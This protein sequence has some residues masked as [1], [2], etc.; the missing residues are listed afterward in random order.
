MQALKD[1]G[2]PTTLAELEARRPI[3]DDEYN[4]ALLIE[5]VSDEL[6]KVSED[7]ESLNKVPIIGPVESPA[8]G[9]P[10]SR[11]QVDATRWFVEAQSELIADLDNVGDMPTGRSRTDFSDADLTTLLPNLS[12]VR[13]AAKIEVLAALH[14]A[15]NHNLTEAVEHCSHA[16]NFSGAVE[17]EPVLISG[18]VAIAVNA[19]AVDTLER[20]LVLGSLPLSRLE[21]LQDQ[22]SSKRR[23]KLAFLGLCGEMLGQQNNY[24][25]MISGKLNPA[26]VVSEGATLPPASIPVLRPLLQPLLFMDQT[27]SLL[28]MRA[29]VESADDPAKLIEAAEDL[30]VQL[31]TLPRYYIFTRMLMP[32]LSV[33]GGDAFRTAW[34]ILALCRDGV[35]GGAISNRPRPV[36]SKAGSTGARLS[37]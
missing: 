7:K 11:E 13:A 36:A 10:W 18:L 12:P 37:G 32:S 3:V 23:Q 2:I 25:H 16:M 31:Q 26:N 9:Y 28:L 20:I 21:S 34:S 27:K 30:D 8:W 1:A 4:S 17:D 29:L 6:T 14:A 19:L 35:G 22:V 15:F 33:A 24:N 5:R